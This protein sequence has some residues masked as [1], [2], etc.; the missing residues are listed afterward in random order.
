[1]EERRKNANLDEENEKKTYIEGNQDTFNDPEKKQI[2]P[3]YLAMQ[4]TYRHNA[5]KEN[6]IQIIGFL[7]I[8]IM[9]IIE[10]IVL[11]MVRRIANR[12]DNF[13]IFRFI[14][15]Y[16]LLAVIT[17]FAC[18]QFLVIYHW[19]RKILNASQSIA[20]SNY[21]LIDKMRKIRTIIICILIFSAIFLWIFQDYLI[22]V[23]V[24]PQLTPLAEK[25]NFY[26]H[27]SRFFVAIYALFEIW[28]LVRWS[29]RILSINTIE[30]LMVNDFPD[31]E[32]LDKL[33]NLP[34][35]SF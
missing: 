22:T 32:E 24:I 4:A 8:T 3:T 34:R 20:A 28:Q 2:D 7:F 9:T 17:I 31:I 27:R 1:M 26:L 14:S 33:A 15:I 19:N 10:M 25:Y 35:D 21:I 29:K 30:K 16:L 5:K 18:Y 23:R 12:N 6:I 13:R 11:G